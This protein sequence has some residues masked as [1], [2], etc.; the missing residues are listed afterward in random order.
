[1]SRFT[2]LPIGFSHAAALAE[3]PVHHRDPFD[4]MLIAQAG[5]EG[6]TVVTH[7]R[8]FEPYRVP[9]LWA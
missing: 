6:L 3:L 9:V 2:K 4:R 1:M 7:D 8:R 5:V